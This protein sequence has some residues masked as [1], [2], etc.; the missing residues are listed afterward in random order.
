MSMTLQI[1]IPD[2]QPA[3]P[4][5]RYTENGWKAINGYADVVDILSE[6]LADAVAEGLQSRSDVL[7]W[8]ND[9]FKIIIQN[10]EDEV[11]DAIQQ[12][13]KTQL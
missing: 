11:D 3:C 8:D 9:E 10:V 4:S 13:Q 7:E 2:L 12:K 1:T 6:K 5:M